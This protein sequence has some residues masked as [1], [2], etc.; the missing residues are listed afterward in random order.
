MRSTRVLLLAALMPASL[1]PAGLAALPRTAAAQSFF[2][3]LFGIGKAAKPPVP[4]R[5]VPTAP[6]AQAPAGDPSPAGAPGEPGTDAPRPA[7][8]PLKPV[9]LKVPA[10]DNVFGQ[11]LMR[12]GSGGSLKLE[13]SGSAIVVRATLPGTKVS[14]AAE[15]C[16]VPL[17]DGAP[18]TLT[19]EA[20]TDGIARFE[21][22]GGE[23]PLRFEVLD[24]AVLV[25]PLSGGPVCTFAAA[26]CATTPGGL[27]GPGAASLIPR[28]GEF[29][30]ARGVADKAV[31][32]NYKVMTQRARGQDVR[33]IVTEQAAFSSDREQICRNYAREG[34]HGFCHVRISEGRAIA[35][36]T[37]L[38]VSPAT[39][40]AP[41]ASAT[42][43]P[44]RPKPAVEGLNPDGGF[45]D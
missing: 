8:A 27:W 14:Q 3:E 33:P 32:D 40:A 21:V 35:L 16:K 18:V 1:V 19:P 25:T 2:E 43:R 22:A 24:G 7:P 17:N 11:E 15:T 20:R 23:C 45:A 30:T 34:S 37:R 39:A 29:D 4:P 6:P 9:M 10:E 26:D 41:S 36:A 13:R 5:G 31:R 44:R 28:S 42:P 12:N 38:G